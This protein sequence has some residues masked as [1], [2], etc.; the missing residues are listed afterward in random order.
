MEMGKAVLRGTPVFSHHGIVCTGETYKDVVKL[1]F[2]KGASLEDPERLF[3]SSLEGKTRRAIDISEGDEINESAFKELIRE[4]V[5]ANS[6][7]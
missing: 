7:R 6:A 2:F 3:N 4:A 5:G 1:T